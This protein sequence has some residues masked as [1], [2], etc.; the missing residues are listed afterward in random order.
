M[1]EPIRYFG[2]AREALSAGDVVEI[3]IDP[4]SGSALVAPVSV[5]PEPPAPKPILVVARTYREARQ[6]MYDAGC[7]PEEWK[8]VSAPRDL[9]G[10]A[11]DTTV[12]G[13]YARDTTVIVL[14]GFGHRNDVAEFLEALYGRGFKIEWK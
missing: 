3:E 11:R 6:A 2:V 12:I 9:R 1:S 10:Y 7:Y 8:Y 14:P 13:G 4:A 5:P